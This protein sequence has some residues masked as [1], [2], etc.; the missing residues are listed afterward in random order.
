MEVLDLVGETD[1]EADFGTAL[2]ALGQVAKGND[3][4]RTEKGHKPPMIVPRALVFRICEVSVL[5]KFKVF[6][7]DVE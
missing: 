1:D 7:D 2:T 4:N 6:F 5:Q 3:L